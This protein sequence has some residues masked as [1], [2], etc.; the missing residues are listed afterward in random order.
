MFLQQDVL[1]LAGEGGAGPR[2]TRIGLG[3]CLQWTRGKEG[4]GYS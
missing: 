4:T 1:K 3:P 2:S